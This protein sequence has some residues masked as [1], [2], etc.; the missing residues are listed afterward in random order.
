[1]TL[2]VARIPNRIK[3]GIGKGKAETEKAPHFHMWG[4]DAL[5]PLKAIYFMCPCR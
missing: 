1:M 5:L 4:C 3:Q 2:E